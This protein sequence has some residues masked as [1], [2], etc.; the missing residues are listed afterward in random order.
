MM[1]YREE[2][3]ALLNRHT[4][5]IAVADYGWYNYVGQNKASH[6][7][8]CHLEHYKRDTIEVLHVVV[9]PAFY[10]DMPIFGL[11]VVAIAGKVT[12]ICADCSRTA[13]P[14]PL[15]CSYKSNR[16]IPEWGTFF[17]DSA[18]LYTPAPEEVEP[19]MMELAVALAAYLKDLSNSSFCADPELIKAAYDDYIHQQRQNSKTLKV[20]QKNEG[21]ATARQFVEQVLFPEL[22]LDKTEQRYA[23]IIRRGH[24]VREA[25]KAEHQAAER[26]E[27]SH[28]LIRGTILK[29]HYWSY[30][31][32][33]K[34]LFRALEAQDFALATTFRELFAHDLLAAGK[35]TGTQHTD[36]TSLHRY[37][38]YLKE[39]SPEAAQSHLYVS[40]L[41]HAYGG[42]Y[43]ARKLDATYPKA[44]LINLPAG[45]VYQLRVA[46]P[47]ITAAEANT[48][49]RSITKIYEEIWQN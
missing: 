34:T 45:I 10:T 21:A 46:T 28:S 14:Y 49:F 12:F 25:T 16:P 8:R 26:S 30:L 19:I 29:R 39:L 18:L 33:Y 23:A 35:H 17:S 47:A 22:P 13:K 3:Q 38:S 7:K 40:A 5:P 27:L 11:D 4:E 36:L 24:E 37:V 20:L 6:I 42:Q 32:A 15:R 43:I 1:D 9:T 48:A 41:G 44:H 2:L 31:Y